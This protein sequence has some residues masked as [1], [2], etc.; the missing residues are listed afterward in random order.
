MRRILLLLWAPVVF[1][2][3]SGTVE[4]LVL[5]SVTGAAISDVG[6]LLWTTNGPHYEAATDSAGRF[7]IEEIK[8]GE[9]RS[10]FEKQ[11]FVPSEDTGTLLRVDS[12][13]EPMRMKV[14]IAPYAS[15]RGR[16]LRP[17]DAAAANVE[18]EMSRTPHDPH[19]LTAETDN[20]GNFAFESIAPG[21]YS[22][23]A[24][25][26]FEISES[27][28]AGQ[29]RSELAPTYYPF[30]TDRGQADKIPI[31]AGEDRS[32][33]N[34]RLQTV[35]VYS[36]RGMVLDEAGKPMPGAAVTFARSIDPVELLSPVFT[37]SMGPL[38]IGADPGAAAGVVAGED[39]RFEI[40]S[41]QSGAW[42]FTAN[43]SGTSRDGATKALRGSTTAI[44][45][46]HD[47]D[48]VQIRLAPLF[49][50]PVTIEG[51]NQAVAG[52]LLIISLDTQRMV[53]VANDRSDKGLRVPNLSPGQY[54]L[55]PGPAPI[56]GAYPLSV[57]LG[58][59]DVTGQ[60]VELTSASPAIRVIYA[61]NGGTVRGTVK[62]GEGA[63]VVL[64][65]KRQDYS[66]FGR[67]LRV[68][69]VGTFEI[70]NVPPG[71][72]YIAAFD[73]IGSVV[74]PDAQFLR[75]MLSGAETVRVEDRG[76]STSNVSVTS[77]PE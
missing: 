17:D 8:P 11:G 31:R 14:E 27:H 68:G 65:S 37:D 21:S 46:G 57:F 41:I 60:E 4:G 32:G 53:M 12:G 19:V 3:N 39:G 56:G 16:V 9:Y 15:L 26:R 28:Q 22:I 64:I 35:P 49:S 69:A 48:D 25:P 71:E 63:T 44:V 30:V 54:R 76:I 47:V 1:A 36:L 58:D 18:I 74:G 52:G 73:R 66:S 6:V 43:S 67:M 33:Y 38:P 50:L 45:A 51:R 70:T 34:I 13:E 7:R 42:Q 75:Q 62:N 59:R 55:I 20:Q 23:L 29:E 2:Q 40:R 61:M 5:N 77:W 72:Y 10:R 24:K